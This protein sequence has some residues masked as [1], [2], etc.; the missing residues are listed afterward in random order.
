MSAVTMVSSKFGA[1]P[2]GSLLSYQCPAVLPTD[3]LTHPNAPEF[4][5][6]PVPQYT[7]PQYHFVPGSWAE[8]MHM[9]SLEVT[10]EMSGIIEEGTRDQSKS[11]LW[12]SMRRL[13]LTASKFYEAARVRSEST[14]KTL[15]GRII[16][17]A[18][19]TKAMRRGVEPEPEVLRRYAETFNVN[20]LPCGL[21]IHPEAPHLG[22]SPDGKVV[23]PNE[24]PPY[25]LVEVKCPD[26][27]DIGEASHT[28]FVGG[29]A[30]LR[31]SHTYHWQVQG[32]GGRCYWLVSRRWWWM[33]LF[34]N[35]VKYLKSSSDTHHLSSKAREMVRLDTSSSSSFIFSNAS[36]RAPN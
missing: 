10:P 36:S 27:K 25:G 22:A 9:Q 17:G 20:V 19:Q 28:E 33:F 16:K 14:A 30:K 35:L 31:K 24:D 3:V 29:Q 2:K 21:M 11:P 4:P 1:V 18:P 5:P 8:L 7:L 12:F 32:G 34:E 26:V 13:R 23:D 15:A 6:L